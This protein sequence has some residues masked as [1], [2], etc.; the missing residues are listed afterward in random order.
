MSLPGTSD[1]ERADE[2]DA[3][4]SERVVQHLERLILEGTLTPGQSLP[5]ERQLKARLGVSRESL[6]T[7]LERLRNRGL[8]ETRRGCGSFVTL[9]APREAPEGL[10]ALM[11]RYPRTLEDLLEVRMVLEG[12]AA[13]LAA[14]RASG[15]DLV[16][17]RR[18]FEALRDYSARYDGDI[19]R[20]ARLDHGF[21]HAITL[22][23]HNP[24]LTHTL[25]GLN[26]WL[27]R[28]VFDTLSHLYHYPA[29]RQRLER[30]HARIF[31]A[32]EARRADTARRAARDHLRGIRTDLA[33]WMP[34]R[35]GGEEGP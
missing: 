15:A 19:A 10:D 27:E 32:L 6:R 29:P 34:D 17:I 26:S 18:A 20:L 16:R 35:P 2:L 23:A 31:R 5:S 13:W 14:E 12:E 25:S 30:Q 21:H 28:S 3:T 33:R 1:T 7:G 11:A 4:P 9:L 24:V 22:A 8:V